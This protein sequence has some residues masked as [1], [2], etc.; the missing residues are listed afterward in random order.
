MVDCRDGEVGVVVAVWLACLSEGPSSLSVGCR[1]CCVGEWSMGRVVMGTATVEVGDGCCCAGSLTTC[2]LSSATHEADALIALVESGGSVGEEAMDDADEDRLDPLDLCT[3]CSLN[4]PPPP[5]A[6]LERANS[7]IAARSCSSRFSSTDSPVAVSQR[8]RKGSVSWHTDMTLAIS[9]GSVRWGDR[10]MRRIWGGV[11]GWLEGSTILSTEGMAAAE[12][13]NEA[14]M[15][16]G[17]ALAEAEGTTI[18]AVA[19]DAREGEAG[20]AGRSGRTVTR[21]AWAR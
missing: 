19:E 2:A 15:D 13:G 8:S 11:E 20:E 9:D 5:P 4:T 3:T 18:E 10:G 1:C 14:G 16:G 12:V 21:A 7:S 17:V 6:P